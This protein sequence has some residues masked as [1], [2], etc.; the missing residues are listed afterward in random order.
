M[1][2]NDKLRG[3]GL[4]ATGLAALALGATLAACD[5]IPQG[6]YAKVTDRTRDPIEIASNPAPPPVVPGIGSGGAGEIPKL[7][8]GAPAGVTQAM[9]EQGA[10]LY[11][12]VCTACHGGG[13]QGTPAAPK[14]ADSEWINIDGS[15]DQIVQVITNGVPQPKAHPGAMPPRGGGNFNEEQI[16]QIS[17]YVFA[18]S[19]Q[20]S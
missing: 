15:F 8:A 17:A 5:L 2:R 4:R 6:G 3:A 19:R 12:T 11:G 16:R 1:A 7:A 13:G 10:D 14:L 18:L 9:V 20:G